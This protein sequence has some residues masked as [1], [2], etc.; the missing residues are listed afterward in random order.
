[1]EL[2]VWAL[3]RIIEQQLAG[4]EARLNA[5]RAKGKVLMMDVRKMTDEEILNKLNS[6]GMRINREIMRKLCRE[7]ISADSLS[8][9]LEKDWKLKLKNYDE[10]WSWLGAKVLWERWY[11]EIPNLEMLDDKMQEG[12]ELLSENKLLMH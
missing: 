6:I 9:W 3:N 4:D 5:L 12:Y 1:M 8:K 10:D 11:P 7:H 2:S